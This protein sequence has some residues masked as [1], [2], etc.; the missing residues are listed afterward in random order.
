MNRRT[1]LETSIATAVLTSLPSKSFAATHQIEKVDVQLYSVRDLMKSDFEGTIAKV[2]AIGYKEVEFAGLF[3]HSPKDVRALLDKD[4]L[5]APSSHVGYDI[6]E[7]HWPETIEA[8]KIIGTELHRL[9]GDSG[10]FA[11]AAG[12]LQAHR[13]TI[14]QSR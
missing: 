4:G 7:N 3:N 1:F 13:R 11:Q 9:P 10:R 2:A 14:Q 5:T 12:W 8:A 6:V